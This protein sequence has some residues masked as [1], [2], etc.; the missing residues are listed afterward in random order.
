M[1]ARAEPLLFVLA[2]TVKQA[3][4]HRMPRMPGRDS[5]RTQAGMK[6]IGRMLATDRRDAIMTRAPGRARR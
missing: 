2:H 1:S 5:T 6:C 3:C 4:T